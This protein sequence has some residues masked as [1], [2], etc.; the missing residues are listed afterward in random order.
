MRTLLI[1]AGGILVL[2]LC[3]LFVVTFVQSL[4]GANTTSSTITPTDKISID[5][6]VFNVAV[7][8][9]ADQQS[10]GL[11]GI[12]S[13]DP[14]QGMYFPLQ[15]QTGISFWMKGMLI[16]I[17]IIWIKQ[18]SIA[19]IDA[20]VLPPLTGTPD[21]QLTKYPSPVANPDAVL[22]VAANRSRDLNF[23]V[24]D[25]VSQLPQ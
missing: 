17:D 4:L 3:V 16:P 5:N 22:E 19:G 8:K 18:G 20:N 15:G 6:Q 21:D 14:N 9:T 23:Q 1:R 2:V 24:G 10:T 11:G 7:A 12:T 13:L 25:S